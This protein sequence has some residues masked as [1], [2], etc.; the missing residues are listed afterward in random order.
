MKKIGVC[1][2]AYD[3]V[4]INECNLLINKLHNFGNIKIYV[5]TNSIEKINK[6]ADKIINIIEPF[7][8][9][10]KRIAV[11][12]ALKECDTI[13]M[14]DSDIFIN[15]NKINFSELNY[16]EDGLY[17]FL[18]NT[19]YKFPI[20]DYNN[21]YEKTLRHHNNDK[22]LLCIFEYLIVLKISD[23]K[24]KRNFINNWNLLYDETKYIQPY[25]WNGLNYGAME[26]LIIYISCVNSNIEVFDS[27]EN[28]KV[29]TFFQYFYHYR[30]VNISELYKE[31]IR[32]I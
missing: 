32:L 11:K 13:I 10:L 23:E 14:M 3:D 31:K 27:T 15:V 24:Q 6:K 7:N 17:S 18:L 22:E 21:S 8:Y 19:K 12:E 20:L 1:I 4:H 9:N 30:G 16:I 28:E 29:S 2:L 5:G 26:G 25:S